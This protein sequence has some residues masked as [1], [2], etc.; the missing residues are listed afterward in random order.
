MNLKLKCAL[1]AGV[2]SMTAYGASI[3]HIQTYAPEY[4]GNQAQNG[5]INGVS[6]YYNPAGTTQLE[7]GLYVNGG[8][9]IAAGHEQSEYKG[10][11]YKAIF[12]QPVPNIS[13]TKVNK[14]DSTYFTFSAIAGGGT[15]KYK[16]GVV[17]TAIIP[18][19]VAKLNTNILMKDQNYPIKVSVLNG[20]RAEGSNL[21]GQ[22]T[23]GKAYQINDKLSLSGG[24]RFV[25]GIRS[26]KGHIEVKANSSPSII[27]K[28]LQSQLKK[29]VLEADIDSKRTANGIGFVLGANYKVN[30]K[31]NIGM[32]YDSRVKLN[33]KAK[34]TEKQISIPAIKGFE[35][36]GFTSNLYYPEYKDG[37]KRRRDLPAILAVGTTYQ[38]TDK[39]M[40]A[41]SANYYF[42]KDA[43]MDGQKYNNGFE[44][45]FGNEYKLNEKWAVLGSINYAKTGALKDS[46]NDIEY[47]LDSFML[48]TGVK[49][50][51]SPTLELTA[52]VAHYFYK[53]EEGNI[54]GRVKEKANPM[55]Q[56]LSNVNEQ[57]KYKKSITAFGLGFTKKF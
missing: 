51:Y 45:A 57:Q 34:T 32:R 3:D 40:T 6:P 33:F 50:Q 39:W 11:E 8:L 44:V 19:L 31:W 25:H 14:K 52:T 17:G 1:L 53:G 56:K 26:L 22:M 48:G 9:Q 7:E 27:D 41:L 28:I 37:A 24:I 36:I 47:A 12:V 42:N 20:T 21:Y 23:L 29:A 35:P 2:L 15:L 18:D 16:H 43:K 55:V 46:Y 5:A 30:E 13:L 10:K 4:L 38:V 49:Y 54:K